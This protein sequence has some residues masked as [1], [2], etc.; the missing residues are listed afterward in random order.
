MSAATE[1]SDSRKSLLQVLQ[2]GDRT[3]LLQNPVEVI[4]FCDEEGIRRAAPFLLCADLRPMNLSPIGPLGRWHLPLGTHGSWFLFEQGRG[5]RVEARIR[6][7]S[8]AQGAA[9]GLGRSLPYQPKLARHLILS[10]PVTHTSTRHRRFQTTFL[11]S[12]A[13]AGSLLR[14]GML[15]AQVPLPDKTEVALLLHSLLLIIIIDELLCEALCCLCWNCCVRPEAAKPIGKTG[16]LSDTD[17]NIIES[18]L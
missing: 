15:R 9:W 11:G 16:R 12:R 18:C 1:A 10:L 4:A 6:V 3:A 5:T 14:S 7:Q 13:M 2:L 8:S 17:N